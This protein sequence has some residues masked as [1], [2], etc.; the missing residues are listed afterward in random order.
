MPTPHIPKLRAGQ[1][2]TAGQWNELVRHVE[3]MSSINSTAFSEIGV[4]SGGSTGAQVVDGKLNRHWAK[5]TSRGT[6]NLYAHTSVAPNSSGGFTDLPQNPDNPYGTATATGAPAR[7]VNGLTNFDAQLPI[8]AELWMDEEGKGWKFDAAGASGGGS[9]T[10]DS[11]VGHGWLIDDDALEDGASAL[12][13]PRRVLTVIIEEGV[14]RCGCIERQPLDE[15]DPPLTA[16]WNSS[17]GTWDVLDLIETCCSCGR[18]R[19]TI[20]GGDGTSAGTFPPASGQLFLIDDCDSSGTTYN[21]RWQCATETTFEIAGHGPKLCTDTPEPPPCDN[22]FR[23]TITCDECDLASVD[24]SACCNSSAPPYFHL[25]LSGFSGVAAYLNGDWYLPFISDCTWGFTCGGVTFGLTVEINGA[26]TEITVT[27][28]GVAEYFISAA[29]S[30]FNC[31]T[32]RTLNRTSGDAGTTPATIT[33]NAIFCEIKTACCDNGLPAVLHAVFS[34]MAG[35]ENLDCLGLASNPVL[36]TWD[37][38]NEWYQ[39]S[40]DISCANC[41]GSDTFCA[42]CETIRIRLF[43]T[44]G[45][46]WTGQLEFLDSTGGACDGEPTTIDFIFTTCCPFVIQFQ[47]LAPDNF[48]CCREGGLGGTPANIQVDI[49]IP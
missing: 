28:N 20:P 17:N 25:P 38:T 45:P 22:T 37:D 3:S 44:G 5:I 24:C 6:G 23:A 39:G 21:F 34:P 40:V 10:N 32:Q 35:T 16:I 2:P 47:I 8:Y 14:G 12:Y 9:T 33:L 27:L 7:E 41:G 29:S 30:T 11:C 19:I 42:D 31:Y 1:M 4:Q 46:A 26:N 36:L 43:C 18:M 48:Q 15:E 49:V 13:Y